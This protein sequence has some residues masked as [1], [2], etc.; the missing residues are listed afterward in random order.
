[1]QRNSVKV[2]F[3]PSPT[4]ELHLGGA[5]TALFNW[6]YAKKCQGSFFLRIEDTDKERSS[7]IYTDQII[8]SLKWLGL[9]WDDP[10]IYQSGRIDRYKY[11]LNRL[12]E[13]NKA[14]RCFC[15]KDDLDK[16]KNNEYFSYPGTCRNLSSEDIKSKLNQGISFTIRIKID[17]GK[18]EFNDLIYGEIKVDHKELDDF[19][20]ARSD[21]SP[22]YNFTVVVDDHEMEISHVIRGDDHLSNTSKQIIIYKTLKLKTPKFAHLPM[23]LGSDKKR[24]SKR[25]GAPGIQNFKDNG[26]FPEV[27]LN[28]LALL[29]WN[30]KNDEEIFSID[31]LI[32][33]F[34]FAQVQ[35]KG[36]S[37]DDKKLHWLSGQYILNLSSQDI[38]DELRLLDSSWGKGSDISHL[39]NIIDA[40]KPRSKSL[41]EFISQ[42]KYFFTSPDSFDQDESQKAWPDNSTTAIVTL[43]YEY[44]KTFESWNSDFIEKEIKKF[45]SENSFGA[46]KVIMPLRLAVFGALNGPSLFEIMHILGKNET[47]SRIQ[48]ALSKFPLK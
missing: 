12:L 9:D 42:S 17:E 43:S 31:Q 14:Y 8:E 4:G 34:D 11:Y 25:H 47:L 23:I 13:E 37:W 30:P 44:L 33:K 39:I 19:I 22:T 28:Y 29:G 40:L 2:R 26:Y 10:I 24:L 3:A 46:G 27:I 18:T 16:S 7:G 20:I 15:S 36:A 6:L 21:G 45:A 38:F 32:D 1:M 41:N 35:K 5:R 48:T